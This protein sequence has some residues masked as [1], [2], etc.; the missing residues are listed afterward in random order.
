MTLQIKKHR[1]TRAGL[2]LLRRVVFSALSFGAGHCA[3]VTD[4]GLVYTWGQGRYGQLGHGDDVD[5]IIP[6]PVPRIKGEVKS[7]SAG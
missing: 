2:S 6:Q 7:V 4:T 3:A 5:K 1:V